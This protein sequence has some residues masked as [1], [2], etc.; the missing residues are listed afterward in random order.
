MRGKLKKYARKKCVE[1]VEKKHEVEEKKILRVT[2]LQRTV[3][4]WGAKLKRK[5]TCKRIANIIFISYCFPLFF[6]YGECKKYYT[7][8]KKRN[9]ETSTL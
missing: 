4:G 6:V 9:V 1:K 5:Q 3:D 2:S 8:K 7:L